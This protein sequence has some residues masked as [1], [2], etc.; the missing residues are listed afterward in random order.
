M[1][2]S[3]AIL[4][5]VW[6]QGS[7]TTTLETLPPPD[8]IEHMENTLLGTPGG[9]QYYHTTAT[10]KL[11]KMT[12]CHFLFLRRAGRMLGSVGYVRR[13]AR[14]G[15][16][17][18]RTW[19]VR[20]FS[21]RAILR[22]EKKSRKKKVQRRPVNERAYSLLRDITH[23]FHDNPE[24]LADPDTKEIPKA[25]I[26]AFVEKNNERSRNFAQIGGFS[27]TGEVASFLFSRLRQR[28][29]IEVERLKGTEIPGMKERLRDFYNSHAFYLDQYLFLNN[30]YYVIRKDGEIV[31]G[32]Q[33]NEEEWK[34]HS[35]GSQ[36]LDRIVKILTRMP[37]IKKRFSYEKMRFLGVEGIYC[38]P[39]HEQ[40][41]YRLL[42]GVL[43]LKNHYLAMMMFDTRAPEFKMF[44]KIKRRG[45]VHRLL[46]NFYGDIFMKFFSF[47]GEEQESTA[48]K[49]VYISIYDST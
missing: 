44:E 48:R 33:A 25:V 38:K 36:F 47:P 39:G 45:P 37:F 6:E 8:L 20:Y 46:G 28:K 2:E 14:S 4:R 12:N 19:F 27:K 26:Y 5:T 18:H 13:D 17:V 10:A 1:P 11:K 7:M 49:P 24:R 32:L 16:D 40:D 30:D 34:I 43:A 29:G 42:E 3:N 35:L 15:E 31:A 41:L 9:L 21:M 22:T 23:N